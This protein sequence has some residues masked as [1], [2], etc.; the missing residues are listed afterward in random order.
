[1]PIEPGCKTARFAF[2]PQR[3]VHVIQILSALACLVLLA[4]ALGWR[5]PTRMQR[6]RRA[7]SAADGGAAA[8][9]AAD[10]PDPMPA[11][12]PALRAAVAGVVAGGVL[13]F[14]FSL[15][16]GLLIAPAT[17]FVLWR[18]IPAKP[19]AVAGGLL[20]AIVVP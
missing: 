1:W 15:R 14:C 16:S 6:R 11:R 19:L 10:W 4:I 12:L 2:A 18:G 20:L 5:L 13:A 9:A 17:A 7:A 8:P 3:P